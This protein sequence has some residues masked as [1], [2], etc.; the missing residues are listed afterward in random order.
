M[1]GVTVERAQGGHRQTR[2]WRFGRVICIECARAPIALDE[3]VGVHID[4]AGLFD[5]FALMHDLDR[6][7]GPGGIVA[8]GHARTDQA[9]IDLVHASVQ[10][11]R[12]VV[13]HRALILE[14][15][16]IVKIHLRIGVANL[17]GTA[18]PALQR[19]VM[20]QATMRTVVILAFDPAGQPS[21]QGGKAGA[22]GGHQAGQ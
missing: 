12:A 13:L 14:Q 4:L 6:G 16:Q 15:K 21:V 3:A 2:W 18:R 9:G 5:R 1:G 17:G 19:R 7:S 11:D 22:V 8:Q 10:R 20:V